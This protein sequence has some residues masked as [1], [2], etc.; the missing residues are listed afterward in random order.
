MSLNLQAQGALRWPHW[1]RLAERWWRRWV[2]ALT[3]LALGFF[4]LWLL[5]PEVAENHAQAQQA[6]AGLQQQLDTL[7][8]TASKPPEPAPT[9]LIQRYWT[10]LPDAARQGQLWTDWQQVLAAHGLRLQS[11][12]PVALGGFAASASTAGGSEQRSSLPHQA[13]ALRVRGRFEDWTRLWAACAEAG[14]VCSLDRIRVAATEQASEVQIEVVLRLWMR[15][16]EAAQ[17]AQGGANAPEAAALAQQTDWTAPLLQT[18]GPHSGLALFVSDTPVGADMAL[19]P[20]QPPATSASNESPAAA[21][22]EALPQD[23][24]QWPLAR[25][26]LA[27]LWQQ[28]PE[29]Q[30][31][32]SA[33]T[34]WARV[35]RGQRVTL[36]GHR[37]VAITDRGVSLRLA[38]GPVIQLDWQAPV[39]DVKSTGGEP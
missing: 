21:G 32:L 23:P 29:R 26:R 8:R 16:G 9:S 10:H 15:P 7:S 20:A 24:R 31:I 12:Q 11:L 3:G 13:A 28:G 38:S 30:A 6:V 17:T 18:F 14:P 22:L 25:V 33:G 37:V 27:G 4:V 2:Y 5:Q 39:S 1:Q 19:R 34:Q 36:E 35:S